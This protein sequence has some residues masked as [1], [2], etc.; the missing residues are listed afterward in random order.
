MVVP[1]MTVAGALLTIARS[2]WALKI[3]RASCRERVVLS[4]GVVAVKVEVVVSVV[5][6]G[7]LA[8]TVQMMVQVVLPPEARL[9]T[10]QVSVPPLAVRIR[11]GDMTVVQTCALPISLTPLAVEGPLFVTTSV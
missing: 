9:P 8:A 6:S 10:V 2:A 7:V 1:A 5:R 11:D 3:G 4:A